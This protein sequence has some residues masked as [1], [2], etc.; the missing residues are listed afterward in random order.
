MIVLH[1]VPS[2][3][4]ESVGGT[5]VYVASLVAALVDEGIAASVAVPAFDE[6]EYEFKGTRVFKVRSGTSFDLRDLNGYGDPVAEQG[7]ERL[8]DRHRPQVLHLHGVTTTISVRLV[9]L[10]KHR[11]LPV[12]LTHHM[13]GMTCRRGT[14]MLW[15]AGP[16]DGRMLEG[17]CA[18]CYLQKRGLPRPVASLAASIPSNI[19]GHL[20]RL[21]LQCRANTVLSQRSLTRQQVESVLDFI[22]GV[23][24]IVVM[25][26]WAKELFMLNG[27][28]PRKIVLSRQGVVRGGTGY[29]SLSGPH[30]D[31]EC[32]RIAF[33]GRLHP[34]KGA[35]V[36]I[37][38]VR[39]S[40]ERSIQLDVYGLD[41]RA[42]QSGYMNRLKA[43][44]DEDP[45]IRLLP[46]LPAPQVVPT[47]RS[48]DAL[49]VPSQCF[50]T[51]PMVVLDAFEA[52]IPVLGSNLGGIRELVSQGD[53]G[54]LLPAT[55]VT[56]WR[57]S[58]ERLAASPSDRQ[59]LR[60][61]IRPPRSTSSVAKDMADTYANL[62]EVRPFPA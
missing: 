16:C 35:H 54:W 38:A 20:G 43:L 14:L 12:V 6:G 21:A 22:R 3:F 56:A 55:S 42:E 29:S 59:R 57:R 44:Q 40:A 60:R 61:G 28:A 10:A 5:E 31:N 15:G 25:S 26:D 39:T 9:R 13:P 23:D 30:L 62:L 36:L 27:I 18:A 53:D 2:Y 47:L 49:A 24:R 48:Y 50:E 8:I 17:R 33:I 58:I 1:V 32:F 7:F 11:G 51:G 34:D 19:G 41:V 45:R 4:P 37:E 46:W 52:G